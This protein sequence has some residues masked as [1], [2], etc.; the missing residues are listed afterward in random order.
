M[1][2]P[3]Q[4]KVTYTDPTGP[5]SLTFTAPERLKFREI[6]DEIGQ[7][8]DLDHCQVQ[9]VSQASERSTAQ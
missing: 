9:Q 6:F 8:I 2:T 4:I 1:P 7:R 3:I 5:H